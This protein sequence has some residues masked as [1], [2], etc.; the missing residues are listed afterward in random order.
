MRF[1]VILI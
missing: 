1:N